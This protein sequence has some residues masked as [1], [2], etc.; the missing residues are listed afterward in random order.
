[1]QK[2]IVDILSTSILLELLKKTCTIHDEVNWLASTDFNSD[3]SNKGGLDGAM[4][5]SK[6]AA[7]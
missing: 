1:M 5:L 2:T 4:I 7:P 3:L 6:K